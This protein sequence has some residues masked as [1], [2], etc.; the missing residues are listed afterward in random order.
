M[1]QF[2]E[3]TYGCRRPSISF[4]LLPLCREL[5]SACFTVTKDLGSV[6]RTYERGFRNECK[7][8]GE[9]VKEGSMFSVRSATCLV[10]VVRDAPT[11]RDRRWLRSVCRLALAMI[12]VLGYSQV[13]YGQSTFG[14]VLGTVKDPSGGLIPQA[15]VSLVN[16]GTNAVRSTLTSSDGLYQFVNTEVG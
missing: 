14:T 10:C 1:N 12:C 9:G 2:S 5:T 3:I 6:A 11:Y 7:F 15:K 16:T 13:S 4:R 8:A